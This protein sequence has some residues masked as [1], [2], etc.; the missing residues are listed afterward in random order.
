MIL[1]PETVLIDVPDIGFKG[2]NVTQANMLEME[3]RWPE[4]RTSLMD[5][6]RTP[7][8]LRCHG[9]GFEVESSPP[10]TSS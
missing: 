8:Q 5:C 3:K 6:T 2:S 1:G 4:T 7:Q 10:W 9:S